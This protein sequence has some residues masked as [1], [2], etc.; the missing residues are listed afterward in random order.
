MLKKIADTSRILSAEMIQKA[1]SGHPGMPLGCAEIGAVLFGE[2]LDYNPDDSDWINRDRLVLS[3]GHGSA[4]LYSF[5]YLAGF[6]LTVSDLKNYRKLDS[7]TP[8]HPE[9]DKT[10]GVEVTTGPLGQG[11]AY[12]IGM[13]LSEKKLSKK[14]NTEDFDLI[15]YNVY[16]M[17]SDGDLM[18]GISYESCS[19]AGHLNLDNLIVIYDKN[20]ISIS[21]KVELAFSEDIEKRFQ[22]MGWQV[23]TINGN[24]IDEIKKALKEAREDRDSPSLIIASTTIGKGL[25]SLEGKEEAHAASIDE[26][27]INELKEVLN[28]PDK[29]FFVSTEI[30][31]YF[32]KRKLKSKKYYKKW[33][34]KFKEWKNKNPELYKNWKGAVN[35][36]LPD[37]LWDDFNINLK[38]DNATRNI[39]GK[40]YEHLTDKIDYVIGGSAD[41]AGSTR[42]TNDNL[43][44]IKAN[45]FSGRNIYFGIREHAM[46]AIAGGISLNGG[47]RPVVSTYL[48]FSDYMR[49][50]IRLSAMMGL[51]VIY[52][53]THDSVYVGGD[54]PTHQPVEQLESLRLIPNLRVMRPADSEE[55][56]YAWKE[57]LREKH[58]PVALVLSRQKLSYINKDLN[59]DKFSQGSYLVHQSGEDGIGIDIFASGS[60]V[61]LAVKVADILCESKD[62]DLRVFSVPELKN[63][64]KI[65]KNNFNDRHKIIIEAAN[66]S[67]WIKY[68]SNAIVFN[69]SS[70]GKSGEGKKVAESLGI[71]PNK[72]ANQIQQKLKNKNNKF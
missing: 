19:L 41:L 25:S 14:Y 13:A 32:E 49:P 57:A 42:L 59:Q 7:R 26:K 5:L 66:I 22:S 37:N 35:L 45:E 33:K 30:D 48:T 71:D 53:F 54:G 60:E 50:S 44:D 31:N 27:R 21:G 15:D 47:L 18:E 11:L 62:Y 28:Y 63:K 17:A 16:V 20:N 68:F 72:I 9:K 55:T 46:G 36:S 39:S 65:K 6:D 58:R 3:A 64:R 38:E 4:W 67:N 8:G 34:S 24:N 56:F 10:P 12:G 1:G 29:E 43:K 69:V 52:I 2:E 23:I 40:I 61:S 70:F 51:A